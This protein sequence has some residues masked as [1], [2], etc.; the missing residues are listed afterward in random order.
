MSD[1]QSQAE[2][3]FTYVVEVIHPDGSR[4]QGETKHNL[5]PTEGRDHIMGVVFKSVGQVATWYIGLY[6]GNYTPVA[7]DT[8]ATIAASSTECTAYTPAARV[9]YV[10]GAVLDGAIDNGASKA[11]FTFTAA[12]TVYGGF[13]VSSSPRGGTTGTLISAVRFSSPKVLAIGDV[14][15]V[16]AGMSLVSA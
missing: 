11:N 6:E 5:V 7:G 14:L 16:A 9:E 1:L 2:L 10:E 15:S 8:A 3:G 13:I 12:K 4:S